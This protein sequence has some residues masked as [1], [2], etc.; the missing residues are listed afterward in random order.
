MEI[1]K[2]YQNNMKLNKKNL[3][4]K[5][6][7]LC[8]EHIKQLVEQEVQVVFLQEDSQVQVDSQEELIHQ[9]SKVLQEGQELVDVQELNHKEVQEDLGQEL[10]KLI[11]YF[12]FRFF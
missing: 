6:C 2:H 7:Q 4:V 11:K 1:K 12:V 8:N 5:L 3:K 10:K 9:C